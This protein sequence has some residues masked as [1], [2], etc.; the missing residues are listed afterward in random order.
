MSDIEKL[1]ELLEVKESHF[2]AFASTYKYFSVDDEAVNPQILQAGFAAQ[3]AILKQLADE[4]RAAISPIGQQPA[5]DSHS[6]RD[7][8]NYLIT[9]IGG[10]TTAWIYD[11]SEDV[12]ELEERFNTK[13]K[14]LI[15]WG[16][17]ACRS[18]SVI[19]PP[20]DESSSDQAFAGGALDTR[21]AFITNFEG[22]YNLTIF[23]TEE[24]LDAAIAE[25]KEEY[26]DMIET[27]E[28]VPMSHLIAIPHK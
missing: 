23:N 2:S 4:I 25:F 5:G 26:E 13:H 28:A 21:Y 9:E 19:I 18:G 8:R 10:Q 27:Q 11:A 17:V 22:N 20:R 14:S 15:E 3:R 6:S 16:E 24:E 7:Y 1:L 12:E